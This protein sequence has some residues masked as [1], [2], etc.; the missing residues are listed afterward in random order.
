ME[1]FEWDEN[2]REMN[3]KKHSIDFIDATHVF[4]DPCRIELQSDQKKEI[5]YK[6]IGM[7]C[8]GVIVIIIYTNRNLKRRLISA[9]MASKKERELYT[10]I[11]AQNEREN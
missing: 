11:E 4:S 7:L 10:I 8:E 5:R 2:K 3:F 9:R 1:H 6:T